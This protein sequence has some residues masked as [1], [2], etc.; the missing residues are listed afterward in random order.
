MLDH[1]AVGKRI[2]DGLWMFLVLD[3]DLESLFHSMVNHES[4]LCFFGD[5]H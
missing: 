5:D 1:P 4:D 3:A 2:E